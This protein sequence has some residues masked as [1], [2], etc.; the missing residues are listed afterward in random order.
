[1]HNITLQVVWLGRLVTESTWEPE[2]SLP[3]I[4]VDDYE[5]TRVVQHSKQMPSFGRTDNM[6]YCQYSSR[7]QP[8]DPIIIKAHKMPNASKRVGNYKSL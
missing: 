2:A 6:H 5:R 1:M 8:T 4:F 3:A 7:C